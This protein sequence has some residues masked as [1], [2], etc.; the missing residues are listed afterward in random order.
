MMRCYPAGTVAG[1][2][3]IVRGYASGHG[4]TGTVVRPGMAPY[5]LAGAGWTVC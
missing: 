2:I 5:L 1:A 3:P 4:E